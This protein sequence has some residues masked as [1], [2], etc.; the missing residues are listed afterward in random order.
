[1]KPLLPGSLIATL[2]RS[3]PS[4]EAT[5]ETVIEAAPPRTIALAE[6]ALPPAYRVA[7][8]K[9]P[10]PEAETT[11]FETLNAAS[12]RAEIVTTS[13]TNGTASPAFIV[14][15]IVVPS[16]V[17]DSITAGRTSR[18]WAGLVNPVSRETSWLLVGS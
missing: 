6:A 12:C 16:W 10:L 5:V 7:T 18:A 15:V 2:A 8:E 17:A 11:A 9:V 14:N 13:P 1:M 3:A 4:V